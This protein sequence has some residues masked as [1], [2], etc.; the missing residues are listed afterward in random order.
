MTLPTEE[1]LRRRAVE[2]A[3]VAGRPDVTFQI[4]RCP[5]Y[6]KVI[7]PAAIALDADL[8]QMPAGVVDHAIAHELGHLRAQHAIRR[9]EDRAYR[10]RT[11]LARGLWA[12][13]LLVSFALV[14][15]RPAPTVVDLVVHVLPALVG[16][17]AYLASFCWAQHRSRELEYEADRVA[18][19]L[20]FPLVAE[21]ATWWQARDVPESGWRQLLSTHPSWE[22]R[23]LA[24]ESG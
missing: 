19:A 20:G 1:D 24:L 23:R 7:G 17:L 22:R 2:I 13:G 16:T 15:T 18:A 9:T 6:A 12:L 8:A 3:A 21:V 4:G 11:T 5:G 14:A 10:R